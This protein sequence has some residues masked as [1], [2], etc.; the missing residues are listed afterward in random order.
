MKSRTQEKTKY[1]LKYKPND[2]HLNPWYPL[3]FTVGILFLI[4]LIGEAARQDGVINKWFS[5]LS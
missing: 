3:L 4:V 5:S 1:E 2:K